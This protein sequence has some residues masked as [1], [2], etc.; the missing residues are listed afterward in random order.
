MRNY[1]LI[2][3]TAAIA[4]TVALA[5]AKAQTPAHGASQPVTISPETLQREVDVRSLPFTL[6][7]EPY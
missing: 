1:A 5:G 6:V 7:E 4:L 2:L 3:A